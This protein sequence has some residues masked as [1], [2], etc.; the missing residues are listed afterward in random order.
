MA[1][2]QAANFLVGLLSG[3]VDVDLD[4]YFCKFYPLPGSTMINNQIGQ[5][6]F[7]NLTVAANAILAQ[8]NNVS[9]L[10]SCPV[11]TSGGYITKFVTI[12]ALQAALSQHCSL[13]GTFIVATPSYVWDN[14]I[15]T[16]VTDVSGSASKQPQQ[17]WRFDFEQ[18]LIT[19]AAAEQVLNNLM[20]KISS[21]QQVTSTSWTSLLNAAGSTISTILTDAKNLIGTLTG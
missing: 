2:T 18:P 12:N 21:G 14:C 6:P 20:S 10:M 15:L 4:S 13:G 7:A 9:M 5:Y 1:L 11:N 3:T 8:P 17:Q 16:R 19:Q